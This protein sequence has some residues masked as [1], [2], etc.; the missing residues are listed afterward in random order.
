MGDWALTWDSP[1]PPAPGQLLPARVVTERTRQMFVGVVPSVLALAGLVALAVLATARR[2][3]ALAVLPLTAVALLAAYVVFSVRYP[4]VDGDTIRDDPDG[5][6]RMLR[7]RGVRRRRP[8]PAR[9]HVWAV[10]T[11]ACLAV[12]VAVQLP[13]LVL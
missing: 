5:P 11:A 7:R 3:A 8:P 4:S 12:I 6:A 9:A 2:S 1:P 13:F 10:V